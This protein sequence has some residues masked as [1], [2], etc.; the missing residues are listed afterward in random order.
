MHPFPKSLK[1]LKSF[2]QFLVFAVPSWSPPLQPSVPNNY[3]PHWNCSS[4]YLFQKKCNQWLYLFPFPPAVYDSSDCFGYLSL[5]FLVIPWFQLSE[6][7]RKSSKLVVGFIIFFRCKSENNYWFNSLYYKRRTDWKKFDFLFL[8]FTS[9]C[10]Q[11]VINCIYLGELV[12]AYIY[13]P[14]SSSHFCL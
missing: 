13:H 2:L 5:S 14:I 4:F 3:R 12:H 11:N 7:L 9:I 1:K 10:L 8:C 6:G